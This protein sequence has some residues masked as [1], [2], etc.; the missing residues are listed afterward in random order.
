MSPSV[1]LQYELVLR[2]RVSRSLVFL[3]LRVM[4]F[5]AKDDKELDVC[6]ILADSEHAFWTRLSGKTPI[7]IE[8][9]TALRLLRPPTRGGG[10]AAIL[11]DDESVSAT[12]GE[13][14]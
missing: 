13:T 7:V 3:A 6:A 1:C 8:W 9:Y 12:I 11:G 10:K 14:H 5:Y 2:K 4:I